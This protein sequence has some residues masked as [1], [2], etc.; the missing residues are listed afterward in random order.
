M[1]LRHIEVF[2]AVMQAGTVSGAAQVLNISQPAVTKVLQHAEARLGMALFDRTRGKFVP[3]PEA[4]RLFIEADKLHSDLLGIRRLAASLKSD[5]AQAVRLAA[6]PALGMT[7]VPAAMARWHKALPGGRCALSTQHTRELVNALLLGEADMALSL[8][9]PRHPGIRAE[10]LASGAMQVLVPL[11]HAAARVGGPLHVR[12][13]PPELIGL[14]DDDALGHRVMA[15]CEAHGEVPQMRITVQT[16]HLARA[17][18]EAGMGLTVVDPFTAAAADRQ[19]VR[20][21]PLEPLLMVQLFLLSAHAAPLSQAARRLVKT[22]R[23]AADACLLPLA[24]TV[25]A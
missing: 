10:A 12:D 2:H 15:A 22:L 14:A 4:Q 7:V 5:T 24:E 25:A 11:R 8:Q 6:T 17:L 19:L 20:L 21:R 3:T 16:Y 9:D 13:L 18:A 23:E 1:R